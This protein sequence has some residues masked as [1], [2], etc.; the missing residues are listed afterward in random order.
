MSDPL[1]V[2]KEFYIEQKPVT[3]EGD[4]IIF[5]DTGSV[6][7]IHRKASSSLLKR[8]SADSYPIDSLWVAWHLFVQFGESYT[9]S[10]YRAACKQ[11]EVD[12]LHT[13]DRQSLNK[14]FLSQ[15][16]VSELKTRPFASLT[17]ESL[18][19]S[20]HKT[21]SEA[22][23]AP[24]QVDEAAI[25]RGKQDWMRLVSLVNSPDEVEFDSV[26]QSKGAESIP[27]Y[28]NVYIRH[29]KQLNSQDDCEFYPIKMETL[30]D[31]RLEF[32]KQ[33]DKRADSS[34]SLF[35]WP[36]IQ[37]AH[38]SIKNISSEVTTSS[39]S[40]KPRSRSG[41]QSSLPII[42]VPTVTNAP[43]NFYNVERFL[44][45]GEYVHA[46]PA[47][48]ALTPEDQRQ[49]KTREISHTYMGQKISFIVVGVDDLSES[50]WDR[51]VAIVLFQPSLSLIDRYQRDSAKFFNNHRG[52]YFRFDNQK[53]DPKLRHLNVCE[54]VLSS[55]RRHLDQKVVKDFWQTLTSF[56]SRR[57]SQFLTSR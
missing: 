41:R 21:Q 16:T 24:K 23:R 14:F 9:T 11:Y 55:T 12:A 34:T 33:S 31:G 25:E 54:F 6:K 2:L 1:H 18:L 56:M 13:L 3:L 20:S 30:L 44:V 29:A 46:T 8:E 27:T 52:I 40:L 35:I 7:K 28:E 53:Q 38:N 32:T 5:H 51:V 43:I 17:P 45:N 57:K 22:S 15:I 42:C 26:I 36:Y 4:F 10:Q 48:I 19:V 37:H 47:H 50:D 39:S 49:V